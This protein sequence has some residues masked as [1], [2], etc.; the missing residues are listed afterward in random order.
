MRDNIPVYHADDIFENM[1]PEVV[2]VFWDTLKVSWGDACYTLI[3]GRDAVNLITSA[4]A[5]VVGTSHRGVTYD[6]PEDLGDIGVYF[7]IRG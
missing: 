6:L 2:K 5:E 7:A 4:A 1:D 3:S